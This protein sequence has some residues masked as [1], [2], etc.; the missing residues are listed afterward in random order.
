MLASTIKESVTTSSSWA[1]ALVELVLERLRRGIQLD[2]R[3]RRGAE[4]TGDE[5]VKSSDRLPMMSSKLLC[6]KLD[7]WIGGVL[8]ASLACDHLSRQVENALDVVV[9]HM[10]DHQQVDRQRFVVARACAPSRTCARRGFRCG[11]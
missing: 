8:C 1:T 4:L 9:V 2:P 3:Q 6:Q 11:S 5:A 10:A 7:T